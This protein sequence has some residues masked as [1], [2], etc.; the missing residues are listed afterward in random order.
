MAEKKSLPVFD[1]KKITKEQIHDFVKENAT[2]KEKESL[3]AK[4]FPK[5]PEVIMEPEM[6]LNAEGKL[7]Q[8]LVRRKQKDGTYKMVPKMKAVPVKNGAVNEKYS[9]RDAVSWFIETYVDCDN[10]KAVMINRPVKGSGN[11]AISTP[12]KDLFADLWE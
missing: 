7:V 8:R 9:H 5:K 4:A 6:V 12:A 3:R 1:F 11:K 2:P 10:P